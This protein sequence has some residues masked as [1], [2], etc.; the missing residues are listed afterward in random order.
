MGKMKMKKIIKQLIII[1]ISI[2]IIVV[3][4]IGT[5]FF[6][7][8]IVR[9]QSNIE[10]FVTKIQET[11]KEWI[12]P[13]LIEKLSIESGD[14]L[15]LNGYYFP[16]ADSSKK[17][18][19]VVHGHRD[20][21]LRMLKYARLFHDDGFNVFVADNRAHD[22]SEGKYTGF[23]WLDRL[24]YLQWLNVLISKTGQDVR[25]V[26]HGVSMGAATVMMLSGEETLP[27]QVKAIIEDCGYTSV[28]EE[29][30]YQAKTFYHLPAFPILNI[31]DLESK[32]FAGY[33]FKEA[34]AI[35]Q[36]KKS[37]TPIFFIHGDAD[38]YVPTLMVYKLYDAVS[39]EKALWIVEGAKHAKAY[40]ANPEAYKERLKSFYVKYLQ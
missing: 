18:A 8:A 11:S 14:G 21:A 15:Q 32:I 29:F 36:V 28:E 39:C 31:A 9:K 30:I 1:G 25:I 17:L 34:S 24:D 38:K 5:Y 6:D 7:Y 22:S 10:N 40:D 33:G 20:G 4:G 13:D 23:G 2:L 35:N 12:N 16:A 3:V 26:L 19:V 37:D 27:E